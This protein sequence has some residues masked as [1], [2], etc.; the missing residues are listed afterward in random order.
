MHCV[1]SVH[2]GTKTISLTEEAYERLRAQR[3]GKA[4]SFSRVVMRAHWED[5]GITGRELLERWRG[6]PAFFTPEAL[7]AIQGAKAMDPPPEDKWTAQ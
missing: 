1:L 6:K 2:M 5:S 4:D 7:E 3:M